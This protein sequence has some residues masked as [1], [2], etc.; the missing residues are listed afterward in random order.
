MKSFQA[1]QKHHIKQAFTFV[2]EGNPNGLKVGSSFSSRQPNWGDSEG[3]EVEV[4]TSS[5]PQQS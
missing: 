2:T 3:S 5:D 4:V 1:A